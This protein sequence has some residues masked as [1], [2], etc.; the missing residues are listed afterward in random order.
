MS[1]IVQQKLKI[2]NTLTSTWNVTFDNP[3]TAGNTVIIG[4]FIFDPNGLTEGVASNNPTDNFS[5]TATSWGGTGQ[6]NNDQSFFYYWLPVAGGATTYSLDLRATSPAGPLSPSRYAICALELVSVD[7]VNA[8]DDFTTQRLHSGTTQSTTPDSLFNSGNNIIFGMV[9]S[10]NS[11]GSIPFSPASGMTLLQ[12]L[13]GS[14]Q[15]NQLALVGKVVLVSNTSAYN[16]TTTSGSI[17]YGQVTWS[18]PFIGTPSLPAPPA[19]T[20]STSVSALFG[21]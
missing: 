10:E 12:E 21:F 18:M 19:A 20:G 5:V 16:L 11:T 8:P 14:G 4:A 15:F 3:V 17:T 7:T 13:D 2:V 6:F 9:C 1:S